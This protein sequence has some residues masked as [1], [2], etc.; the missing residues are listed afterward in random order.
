MYISFTNA[1]TVDSTILLMNPY[2]VYALN[3]YGLRKTG[4]IKSGLLRILNKY[5]LEK[6]SGRNI[7]NVICAGLIVEFIFEKKSFRC[8]NMEVGG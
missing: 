7:T 6:R 1:N 3:V 5:I 2:L 8:G 4:H